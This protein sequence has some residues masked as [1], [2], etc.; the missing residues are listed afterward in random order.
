V[1]TSDAL[2]R[3]IR[4]NRRPVTHFAYCAHVLVRRA[5]LQLPG[6]CGGTG[7]FRH[8]HPRHGHDHASEQWRRRDAPAPRQF[9]A[10]DHAPRGR[11]GCTRGARRGRTLR[12]SLS[13]ACRSPRVPRD[14]GLCDSSRDVGLFHALARLG[15]RYRA[16][17]ATRQPDVDARRSD[18]LVAAVAK[19]TSRTRF[20]QT[21][22]A[23]SYCAVSV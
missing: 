5:G 17:F 19:T 14:R 15:E 9:L 23:C 13:P 4:M 1:A 12:G 8:R 11:G 10:R 16:V 20:P 18:G 6:G 3:A 2:G 21:T 22:A 7:R